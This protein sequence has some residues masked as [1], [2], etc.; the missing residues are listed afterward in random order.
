MKII[1][2]TPATARRGRRVVVELHDDE[3]M[4]TVAKRRHYRLGG[5][6]GDIVSSDVIADA[7]PVAW[8]NVQQI[9]DVK[10]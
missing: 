9:W 7:K 6:M 4:V 8:C 3:V 10:P 2:D 5:Q 1:K